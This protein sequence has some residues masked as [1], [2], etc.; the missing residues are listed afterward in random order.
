M[1]RIRG[2]SRIS[3]DNTFGSGGM[4]LGFDPFRDAYLLLSHGA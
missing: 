4:L 2:T 3:I 1:T